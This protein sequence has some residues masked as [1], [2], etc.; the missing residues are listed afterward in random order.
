M[1]ERLRSMWGSSETPSSQQAYNPVNQNDEESSGLIASTKQTLSTKSSELLDNLDNTGSDWRIALFFLFF[2]LIFFFFA[3]TSLPFFLFA[4]KTTLLYLVY[5]FTFLQCA[6]AFYW[7]PGTY[8][9]WVCSRGGEQMGGAM[10][11]LKTA[12]LSKLIFRN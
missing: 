9:K 1:V 11:S 6:L 12:I 8:I 5:G 4:P 3:F 10:D 7:G 2:S